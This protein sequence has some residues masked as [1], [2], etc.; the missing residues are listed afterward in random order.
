MWLRIH[1]QSIMLTLSLLRTEMIT[2]AFCA[3]SL[4]LPDRAG[5]QVTVG[6]WDE[7]SNFGFTTLTALLESTGRTNGKKIR[8]P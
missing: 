8:T 5:R 1:L 6:G 2:D 3:A 7:D 4:I